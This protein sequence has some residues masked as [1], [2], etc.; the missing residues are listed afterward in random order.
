MFD[1]WLGF[2]YACAI[3]KKI[4]LTIFEI[5]SCDPKMVAYRKWKCLKWISSYLRMAAFGVTL[6]NDRFHIWNSTDKFQIPI[7]VNY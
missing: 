7:I 2:E 1:V 6:R 4:Y 5:K 3:Q